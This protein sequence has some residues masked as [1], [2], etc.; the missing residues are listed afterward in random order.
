MTTKLAMKPSTRGV[1]GRYNLVIRRHD[2]A[3]TEYEH[4]APLTTD[5]AHD[6]S[7][8]PGGPGWVFDPPE[9]PDNVRPARLEIAPREDPSPDVP[10]WQL[11]LVRDDDVE[12]L[13]FIDDEMVLK[14]MGLP[15]SVDFS[16]GEPDW[17][18]HDRLVSRFRAA[19]LRAEADAID[20]DL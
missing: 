3:G 2:L 1:I 16:E 15:K 11:S 7:S 18:R 13:A 8:R 12:R 9:K 19:A 5:Q 14:L 10:L 6:L 4:V 17:A 20:P